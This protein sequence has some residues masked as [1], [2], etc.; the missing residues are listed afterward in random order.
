MLISRRGS[1]CKKKLLVA[2][3]FFV[4]NILVDTLILPAAINIKPRTANVTPVNSS[5]SSYLRI[6]SERVTK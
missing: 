4:K 2:N 5:R 1:C 6:L 3:Q